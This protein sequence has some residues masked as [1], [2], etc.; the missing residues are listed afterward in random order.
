MVSRSLFADQDDIGTMQKLPQ[1]QK[2]LP[3]AL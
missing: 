1:N 2:Y 3:E